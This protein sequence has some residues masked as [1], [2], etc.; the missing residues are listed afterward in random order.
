MQGQVRLRRIYDAPEPGDGYR[1]LADR[2]WPRGKKRKD[3]A[4]DLWAKDLC[5]STGLRKAYHGGSLSFEAFA[6]SFLQELQVRPAAGTLKEQLLKR[7]QTGPVTLL[8]ANK[9][10]PNQLDVL[11][12]YLLS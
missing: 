2:L 6:S 11:K 7:L 5:P 1:V 8:T 4:L 9:T 10:T 12:D 3:A